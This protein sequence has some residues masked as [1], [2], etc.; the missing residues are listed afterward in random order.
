MP[1]IKDM[2]PYSGGFDLSIINMSDDDPLL[3]E[4]TIPEIY[5]MESLLSPYL[6]TTVMLQ[7]PIHNVN[8]KNYDR[9]KFKTI[10]V[11][12]NNPNINNGQSYEF[13]QIIY[14]MEKR[15]PL[16]EGNYSVEEFSLKSCDKTQISDLG[17][18]VSKWWNCQTPTDVVDEALNCA[19]AINRDLEPS[20]PKRD[21]H[22]PNIHPFQVIAEQ[23]NVALNNN[24]PAFLHYMTYLNGGTHHFRSLNNLT[25]QSSKWTYVYSESGL[26][27]DLG[28][29]QNILNYN[30]PCDFDGLTDILNG[31]DV[32]GNPSASLIAYNAFN[33]VASLVKGNLSSCGMSGALNRVVETT[34]YNNDGHCGSHIEDYGEVRKARVSLI[35]QDKIML[36]ITVPFNPTLHVGDMIDVYFPSKVST[37]FN[38]G[39]GTYLIVNMMNNIKRGGYATSVLECVSQNVG[40]Y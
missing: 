2:Y 29:T 34:K 30:F 4:I 13:Q 16:H 15:K 14:R 32:N 26:G 6:E 23:A 21:Y 7:S 1:N 12:M 3:Y 18:R 35:Q 31:L 11:S 9:F 8:T 36:N 19:G 27:Q 39:S 28:N 17:T 5:M 20:Q 37:D 25:K 38:H 24:D 33:G 22:A 40:N 10:K